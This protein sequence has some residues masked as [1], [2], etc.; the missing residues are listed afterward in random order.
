MR[1]KVIN[2]HNRY[3]I[4]DII[5]VNGAFYVL[6]RVST[7]TLSLVDIQSGTTFLSPLFIEMEPDNQ[8]YSEETIKELCP[9]GSILKYIGRLVVEDENDKSRV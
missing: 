5:S 7:F 3:Y 8:G 9:P 1:F 2:K 6:A 4:G